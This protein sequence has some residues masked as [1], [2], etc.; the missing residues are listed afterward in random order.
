MIDR[1]DKSLSYL[2]QQPCINLPADAMK[3]L[4]TAESFRLTLLEQIHQAKRRIYITALYL[5]NDEA[6]RQIMDALYDAKSKRPEL[7]IC[8]FV[9]FHRAQRSLIGHK[10]KATNA[11]YYQQLSQERGEGIDVYGIPVKTREL[12]GVLH[13]KGFVFDDTVLYS[14][15]S[16]NNIY[17]HY[18]DRYRYDRYCLI[19]SAKLADSFVGFLD[20]QFKQSACVP[21]LNR[22]PVPNMTALKPEYR[23]FRRSLKSNEYQ[24][25]PDEAEPA[26]LGITPLL[27]FGARGNR[28]NKS[29]RKI[30]Q[31]A[32]KK[33]VLFTPYFN[34]PAALSR[35]ISAMLRRGVEITMVVGDKTANDFYIPPSE[36]FKAIGGLPYLYEIN[37]RK[38]AKRHQKAVNAGLLNINVWRHENH[39]FHLKGVYADDQ[40]LLI[41]GNNLNP[42]AWRLDL[43]NGLLINDQSGQLKPVLTRELD[44]VLTHARPIKHFTDIEDIADYPLHVKKLLT[45]MRAIRA[46]RMV[47]GII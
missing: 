9:D 29:I 35:D 15:A 38:F 18:F 6:G 7:E 34:L 26:Q 42:R 4:Y 30:F 1:L 32:Q 37:L 21:P 45:R 12:F 10:D 20:R 25:Q 33:L 39:S 11:D 46:D 36:D 23:G 13:L 24:F 5:E 22:G 31:S 17:L 28:L 3:F 8:V 47:K 19:H 40:R 2:Q 16:L 44:E 41:T 14:G 27:G 43:E